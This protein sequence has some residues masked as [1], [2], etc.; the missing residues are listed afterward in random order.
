M[1]KWLVI[2]CFVGVALLIILSCYYNNKLKCE[3]YE[4]PKEEVP[5]SF[6]GNKIIMLADL[7]EHEF[8]KKNIHL[9]NKIKEESPDY[10]VIAGDLFVK[11]RKE[12]QVEK[13]VFFLEQLQRIATV[14]YA[15]GNHELFLENKWELTGEYKRFVEKIE[16]LGVK[17][18]S[19]QF[20]ELEKNNQKIRITGLSLPKQYY[21]KFYNS[22]KL[23]Q[24]ALEAL[25]G[26]AEEN[27]Y[28][29]LI[30]H[31]PIYFSEYV[32][33]GA[34]LV[35]AGHV[36]GGIVN[37]PGLGG[38]L[39]TTYELFPKYDFGMFQKN[40]GRMV[41]TRG[42]GTHTIKIRLFNIPEVS[43]ICLGK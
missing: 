23:E 26:V 38:V 4:I 9:L 29:I 16:N 19:N 25:I 43:V 31:N 34:N 30:A 18:L 22:F 5:E 11:K 35:L 32:K 20:I 2:I 36:H 13:I 17:Y 12:F 3:F 8:G 1:I 42:L 40:M 27:C 21:T 39:S 28:N 24:K 14:F 15:P 37:L 33:W 10:I 7:H 6:R 41:L